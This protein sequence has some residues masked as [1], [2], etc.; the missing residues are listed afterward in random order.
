MLAT[1]G[2]RD[3]WEEI[4]KKVG[5]YLDAKADTTIYRYDKTTFCLVYGSGKFSELAALLGEDA[6][7]TVCNFM[8]ALLKGFHIDYGKNIQFHAGIV[9][10]QKEE[11]IK[12]VHIA[13][14]EAKRAREKYL[15]VFTNGDEKA[16]EEARKNTD[17]LTA[18]LYSGNI[19]TNLIPHYQYIYD[20]KNPAAKKCEAL[21]RIEH[22]GED[23]KKELIGPY[24]F[25][26][27]ATGKGWLPD[28]TLSMLRQIIFD[29]EDD[30]D[31]MVS[32]N[33]HEQD[34]NDDRI[35]RNL[36]SIQYQSKETVKRINLEILETVPFDRE[37]DIKKIE[38][39]KS[40][41]YKI[42]IDDYGEKESNLKKIILINPDNIKIDKEVVVH[43]SNSVYRNSAIAA[44]RSIVSHAREI[45]ATVTAEYIESGETFLLLQSLGVDFF[46]G[47]HFAKPVSFDKIKA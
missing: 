31:L 16:P 19:H 34:W 29:M 2:G 14:T 9:L 28:I 33:I 4:M 12:N 6:N 22:L 26:G 35:M 24:R 39:L 8:D 38:E 36:R 27:I 13:L 42:S 41:G 18:A 43:T 25:I 21:A 45:G 3:D 15:Y 10:C 46:Q 47:Y 32:I 7:I 17:I 1:Q 23:G 30:P 20:P 37:D 5:T 11:H 40:L 44:I